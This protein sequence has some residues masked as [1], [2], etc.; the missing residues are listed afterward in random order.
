MGKE[1]LN[2]VTIYQS[3]CKEV[4]ALKKEIQ[5]LQKILHSYLE[6]VDGKDT[7]NNKNRKTDGD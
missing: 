6:V 2:W 3:K 5:L 4:Q 1:V 7:N